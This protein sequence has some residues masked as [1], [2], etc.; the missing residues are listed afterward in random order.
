MS[1]SRFSSWFWKIPLCGVAHAAG[2]E[3]GWVLVRSLGLKQMPIPIEVGPFAQYALPVLGGM[4][5]ALGLAS[6]AGSL[7]AARWQRWAILAAFAF[8]ANGVTVALETSIFLTLG[9]DVALATTTLPASALCALAVVWYFPARRD[10]RDAHI[11]QNSFSRWTTTELL[12]RIAAVLIA[13]PLIY[14]LFGAAIAPIVRPIYSQI[15]FLVIPSGTTIFLMQIL[16]STLF[17]SIS[18]PVA[19]RWSGTR[20]ALAISLGLAHFACVGLNGL[21]QTQFFPIAM[22]LAHGA[23]VFADSFAYAFVF[24]W[25]FGPV[26]PN[27]EP[28][29]RS[30]SRTTMIILRAAC[31]IAALACIIAVGNRPIAYYLSVR[32]LVS[33]VAGIGVVVSVRR[34]RSRWAWVLGGLIIVFNPL[35]SFPLSR[36]L[37]QVADLTSAATLLAWQYFIARNQPAS[38]AG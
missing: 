11:Q 21:I 12:F 2:M 37:W 25:L 7:C 14:L 26:K 16:R 31:V 22:R 9:G 17:F 33:C 24:A 15:E 19:L 34:G 4:V 8:I 1:E 18:I 30:E 36:E 5:I 13:F 6:M 32:V 28:V 27:T 20:R 29:R 3:L 23:E 10:D 35:S 38:L